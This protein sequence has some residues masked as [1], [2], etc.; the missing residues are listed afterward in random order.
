VKVSCTVLRGL[1]DGNI[2]WLPDWFKRH[3]V[4]L[5]AIRIDSLTISNYNS[6]YNFN[7]TIGGYHGAS[8]NIS[9]QRDRKKAKKSS[10]IQPNFC[11]QMG[12]VYHSR[13]CKK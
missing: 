9:R 10:Q 12:G 13:A 1:G 3:L 7:S 6:N 5:A 2:P 8:Y 11:K 4:Q